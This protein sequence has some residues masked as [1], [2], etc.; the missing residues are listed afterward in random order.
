VSQA[1][2]LSVAKVLGSV[3]LLAAV[4]Y[5]VT[6]A[7]KLF[8]LKPELGR[9]LVHVSLG[10]YCL[11]FPAIFQSVWEVAAVCGLAC[12]VFALA[13]GRMRSSLG[14]GLHAVN[15]VSY[16]ELLFAL[17][18]VLLFGLKDGHFIIAQRDGVEA[19]STVLYVLPLLILTLCDASAALVGSSYGRTKFQVEEGSKSWEGVVVFVATAWLLSMIVLLLLSDTPRVDV[20]VLALILALFGALFEAAS[21]RGLDNLFIPMGL[22]F[23]LANLMT[24]G[25]EALIAV[26]AMFA[27]VLA[28]ILVLGRRRGFEVHEMATAATLFFCIAI[29]SGVESILT[30]FGA[31]IAYRL[32]MQEEDEA[33]PPHEV[34][35]LMLTIVG[36]A[37]G[38]FLLT[39]VAEIDTIFGFNLAFACLM[40]AIAA[41]FAEKARLLLGVAVLAWTL[42]S[43]RTLWMAGFD[44]TT[45]RFQAIAVGAMLVTALAVR[46]AK[47]LF[48]TR[49][50]AAMGAVSLA[51]G[52]GALAVAP[53]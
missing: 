20:V 33:R 45:L 8:K 5:G 46:T 27:A 3:A 6:R 41:R 48:D 7:S 52:A 53:T 15:R 16:G 38:F 17:S 22:Y 44:Q 1:L 9:K 13:R 31:L 4:L 23:V 25:T 42:M 51:L 30:P 50:W 24:R 35:N 28:F 43:V 26:S 34:L 49:P 18:V 12:V 32:V 11:T 37:L 40:V 14:E 29:F 19:P 47:P 10:L 36:V 39:D 21:W 2:I